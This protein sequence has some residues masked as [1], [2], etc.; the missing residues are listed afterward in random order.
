MAWQTMLA[1]MKFSIT[2]TPNSHGYY[3][4]CL[5]FH[6]GTRQCLVNMNKPVGHCQVDQGLLQEAP[7]CFVYKTDYLGYQ[8]KDLYP[9][10][11]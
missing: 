11:L 8:T 9:D 10:K 1:G 5:P 7:I 4:F 3:Y 6:S 2:G